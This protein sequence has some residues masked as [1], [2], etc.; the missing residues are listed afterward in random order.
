VAVV[1]AAYVAFTVTT[2][3]ERLIAIYGDDFRQYCQRVPRFLPDFRLFRSPQTIEV[4]V[5]G[6]RSELIRT[7][8]WAWIPILCDL[9]THLRSEAW[10]PI[11]LS[12]L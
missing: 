5:S 3:E 10:W 9:A 2:E 7:C 6:L 12:A 4:Q 1:S 11:W 8:R